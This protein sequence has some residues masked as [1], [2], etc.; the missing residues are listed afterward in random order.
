MDT[1]VG[2]DGYSIIGQGQI[3]RVLSSK[4]DERRTLFEEAAGISRSK[5]EC[6]EA[7][8][9]LEQ[10]RNNMKQIEISLAEI[11]HSYDTLKVQAEKT[12]KYRK[13]KDDIFNYELDITLIRLKN[14]IQDKARHEQELIEVEKKRNEIR[15]AIEEINNTVYKI[16]L[17]TIKK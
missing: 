5:V 11:K 14:F 17:E 1:G 6:A 13:I 12:T 16:L 8:R 9:E 10:T 2:K 7:E 15:N 4:P 3:D